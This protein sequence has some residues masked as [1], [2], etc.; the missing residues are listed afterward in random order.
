MVSV[1]IVS[2]YVALEGVDGSGKSTVAAALAARLQTEGREVMIVREP[3]GTPVG[4]AIRGLLLDSD[5][6]DVWTEALLFAAQRAELTSRV[7]GPALERG[8]WVISDRTYFSSIAY[9]GHA[10]GLGID[11]VRDINEAGLRGVVPGLVLVLDTD[12]EHGLARQHR[13]DRIGGE[14]LAFQQKVRE[15]YL[16]LAA[17]EPARVHVLDGSLSVDDLVDRIMDLAR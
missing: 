15:G 9:Q 10:R 11:L 5:S 4:E 3:G 17:A 2:R 16:M 6:L 8:V 7:V 14:G 12:P 13:A 1:G